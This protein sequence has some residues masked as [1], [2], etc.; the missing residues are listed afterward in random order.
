[1]HARDTSGL[2]A[3]PTGLRPC[4]LLVSGGDGFRNTVV[5]VVF[6]HKSTIFLH[7]NAI[8]SEIACSVDVLKWKDS[9]SQSAIAGFG[10][11]RRV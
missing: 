3:R 10:P 1:M 11:H 7:L 6:S 2:Y 4:V 5:F 8:K 9:I